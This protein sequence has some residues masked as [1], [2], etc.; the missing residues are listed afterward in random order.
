M[1]NDR[2][3]VEIYGYEPVLYVYAYEEVDSII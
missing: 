2:L 3:C 1:L